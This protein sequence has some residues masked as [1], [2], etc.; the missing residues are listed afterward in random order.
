MSIAPTRKVG[1]FEDA[2][3]TPI[4]ATTKPA[5][6]AA[7]TTINATKPAQLQTLTTSSQPSNVVSLNPELLI[8]KAI[9]ANVPVEA[10]ERLLAM[11]AELKKEFARE[12]YSH[13]L[14]EFQAS[15]PPIPKSKTAKVQSK[16]GSSYV[17]HYADIADI[18]RA[19]APRMRDCGLS[20]TFDTSQNGDILNIVCIVHHTNGHSEQTTFPVPID[21]QARMND[22]QKVGSALTYGRRYALCAALGIVTA[23]DDDDAQQAPQAPQ[24]PTLAV[25]HSPK[26]SEPQ[27]RMLEGIIGKSGLNREWVK[28]QI[29]KVHGVKH[30]QDLEIS[31]FDGLLNQIEKWKNKIEMANQQNFGQGQNI[32]ACP[33]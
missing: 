25:E 26:I 27:K 22:T 33:F 13:A 15:I 5:T 19:I 29:L 32:D 14:A 4:P 18:Q 6:Q 8:A 3:I 17:Y 28:G 10:L 2:L 16:I 30:F 12:A 9:E 23:E 11:R 20:V 31:Q 1:A 24:A 7:I 21:R